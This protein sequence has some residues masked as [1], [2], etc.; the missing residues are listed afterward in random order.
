MWGQKTVK[1][2]SIKGF[3]DFSLTV[4]F[5]ELIFGGGLII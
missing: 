5:Y 4:F 1:E 2:K 3:I